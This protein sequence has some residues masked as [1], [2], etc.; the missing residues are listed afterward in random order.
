MALLGVS[1][2]NETLDLKRKVWKGNVWKMSGGHHVLVVLSAVVLEA[3]LVVVTCT[4]DMINLRPTG[5]ATQMNR[6]L[7]MLKIPAEE[8]FRYS[9]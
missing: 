7:L 5:F 3:L 8:A 6:H 2:M 4:A 9:G 1:L